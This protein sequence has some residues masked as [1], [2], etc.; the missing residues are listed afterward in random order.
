MRGGKAVTWES[1]LRDATLMKQHN[2]NACR[3]SHYPNSRLW[4]QI[5]DALG[6][7]VVD[8]ANIETHG[9][10]LYGSGD[11][12]QL[13]KAPSWRHAFLQRFCRM[14]QRDKNHACVIIWSLGNE[15]GYGEAHDAMAAWA[16]RHEPSR[17][18]RRQRAAAAPER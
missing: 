9:L 15:S 8:E 11:A 5:C 3:S 16:R 10:E 12:G 4:Y 13:A 6:L 18:V 1:M 17:P 2:I 14:V 7:Y